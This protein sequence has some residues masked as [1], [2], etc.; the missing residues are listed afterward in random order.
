[1]TTT[2]SQSSLHDYDVCARR[3]E[4][5]YI[6]KLAWPALVAEP[7]GRFEALM[8]R[9]A[10]FHQMIHQHHLGVPAENIT[11]RIASPE[12]GAWW[13]AYL[14]SPYAR[15]GAM[16][17]QRHPEVMLHA[18]RYGGRLIAKYDLLIFTEREALIVDW[19]TGQHTPS[20]DELRGRWQSKLYPYLLVE[21]GAALAGRRI[22]PDAVRMVYWFANAPQDAI[23]LPY[24]AAQHA[25][26]GDELAE[27]VPRIN[28][29]TAFDMTTDTRHC[30]LCVYRSLC[31]RG[32]SA[33]DAAAF[34]DDA[35][36]FGE[37]D[38]VQIDMDQ[39]IE[40]EF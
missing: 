6:E 15:D 7:A 36:P 16:V 11:A 22:E 38:D 35:P 8:K 20:A 12:V 40:I 32:I 1:M 37:E 21:A 39:I 4:L 33:G 3:F 9:G 29:Q 14:D 17:G 24:D 13:R 31:D 30:R 2:F 28:A 23:T 27:L 25:A 10:D 26:I 5:K 18:N 34:T 19:K